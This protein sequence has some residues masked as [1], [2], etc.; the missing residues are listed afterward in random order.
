MHVS[1][2]IIGSMLASY[3]AGHAL[4]ISVQGLVDG[5]NAG[6]VGQ[7]MGYDRSVPL[8]GQDL[9]H[10]PIFNQRGMGLWTGCGQNILIGTIQATKVA[11]AQAGRGEIAQAKPGGQVFVV[12]HQVNGD[13]NGP[14]TCGIDT[15]GTAARGSFKKLEIAKQ[16]PGQNPT[17]NAVT[18]TNH[19]LIFNLPSDI[20]CTGTA[21]EKK[22]ICII[23][24][25]NFAINGPFGSCA[26]IQLVDDL[27][28]LF[29]RDGADGDDASEKVKRQEEAEPEKKEPESGK[30]ASE[31]DIARLMASFNT[32]VK[33]QEEVEPE[34]KQPEVG[35]G[36]SEAD[37]RKLMSAFNTKS[38]RV[39][40]QT[41]EAEKVED[42]VKALTQGDAVP[43][44]QLNQL[45][46]QVKQR[47]RNG[48]LPSK[49]ENAGKKYHDKKVRLRKAGSWKDKKPAEKKNN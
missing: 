17:L 5:K 39:K 28:S 4:I 27:Q 2:L 45:R 18:A 31:A 3:V 30:G 23:R 1:S 49:T 8:N 37:I 13:G 20:E 26:A 7:A 40:R 24:C 29:K 42:T 12:L 34:Q 35:K 33:R 25:Q 10:V 11:L 41:S 38:K 15:T 48:T 47:I 22:R 36:A 19:P 43:E 9:R 32:K 21:G 14:F 44:K 6:P 16:V 46:A